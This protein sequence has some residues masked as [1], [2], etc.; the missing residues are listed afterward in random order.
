LQGISYPR[1]PIVEAVIELRFVEALSKD[2]IAKIVR[3]FGKAYPYSDQETGL[4]VHVDVEKKS[5][6]TESNW[7]GTKLSSLDRT[8]CTIVRQQGFSVSQLA[9]YAGWDK[10]R[11]RAKHDWQIAEKSIG[12]CS[13]SRIGVR[14]INRLDIPGDHEQSIRIEDYLHVFPTLPELDWLPISGYV[15]QVNRPL[16]SDGCMITINSGTVPSP[17]VGYTSLT[18]DIDIYVEKDIPTKEDDLWQMIDRIRNHKNRLF[19]ACIT[20]QARA[21]FT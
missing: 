2:S 3:R 9:P 21:L 10:F 12:R 18:L 15:M 4:N 16:A 8:E 1:P 20:D 17:L 14:Y 13:I 7:I 5:A 19:E 11:D 6:T